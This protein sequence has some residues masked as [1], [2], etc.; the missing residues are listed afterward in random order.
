MYEI[1]DIKKKLANFEDMILK[2]IDIDSETLIDICGYK[3]CAYDD[4][5]YIKD[6]LKEAQA[7]LEELKGE[8]K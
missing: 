3:E 6:I 7:K 1:S 2:C 5:S 8:N 4:L